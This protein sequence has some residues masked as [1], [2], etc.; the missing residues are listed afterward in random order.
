MPDRRRR[1]F[2]DQ[3]HAHVELFTGKFVDPRQVAMFVDRFLKLRRRPG[4][5]P[6]LQALRCAGPAAAGVEESAGGF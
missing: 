5:S 3:R 1:P 4:S 6:A 2:A